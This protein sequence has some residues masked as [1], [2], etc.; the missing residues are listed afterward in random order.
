MFDNLEG[1]LWPEEI[2]EEEPGELMFKSDTCLLL[3]LLRMLLLLLLFAL[4]VNTGSSP[5]SEVAS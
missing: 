2:P 4:L 1:T 3:L 5:V